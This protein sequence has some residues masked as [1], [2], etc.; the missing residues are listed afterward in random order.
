MLWGCTNLTLCITRDSISA[1]RTSKKESEPRHGLNSFLHR[2]VAYLETN[3]LEAYLE[4]KFWTRL[5]VVRVCWWGELSFLI[6]FIFIGWRLIAFLLA[7]SCP[8]LWDPSIVAH[9]APLPMG[10]SRQGYWSGLPFPPQR[11]LPDLET[12]PASP[13]YLHRRLILCPLSLQEA[14]DGVR[15]Q[16]N[17]VFLCG[18]HNKSC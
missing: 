18:F 9:Q 11:D 5:S 13:V 10:L 6:L 4:T 2:Q 3:T 17:R 8:T 7:Q 12:E 1:W 16:S 14:Q 15:I